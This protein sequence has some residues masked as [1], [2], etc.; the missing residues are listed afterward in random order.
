MI[1]DMHISYN[2]LYKII[3]KLPL[4]IFNKNN[5]PKINRPFRKLK[6]K[7]ETI[8]TIDLSLNIPLPICDANKQIIILVN[9]FM[10]IPL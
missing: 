8:G 10:P 1:I 7:V 4:F 3:D 2:A 6:K 9:I 5:I